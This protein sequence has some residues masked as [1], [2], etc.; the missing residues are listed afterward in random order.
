VSAPLVSV[1][2]PVYNGADC[3]GAAIDSILR[4]TFRDFE[5]I[6]INDGSTRDDTAGV[7]E[8]AAVAAGDARLRVVN[9]DRNR[10]LAGALN[11]GISLARGRY[12]ARQDQDDISL[13]ERLEAQVQYLE[14][15]PDCALLG[16]RAEVWVGKTPSGRHLDHPIDNASLQ[17]E[18][19]INSPFVHPSV[20]MRRSALDAVGPY[21]TAADRQPEDFELWSRIARRFSVANLP[22]R[23][24]IYREVPGSMSRIGVNPF[25]QGVIRIAT[26][27]LTHAGGGAF[28]M[29]VCRDAAALINGAYD[30]VSPHCDIGAI[31]DLVRAAARRIEADNPGAD[32]ACRRD[33]LIC[34][35]L[36]HDKARR[37]LG[38]LR[39]MLRR[40]PVVGPAAMRLARIVRDRSLSQKTREQG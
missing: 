36:E 15:H 7:L 30:G 1:I 21:A 19:L 27:N 39:N 29:T 24:V 10:G 33:R 38:R 26:E 12:I 20:V 25:Q 22:E 37:P 23:L 31:C 13:P 32:L 3:V 2:L 6:A 17:F 8:R 9:L 35:L 14:A 28:P 5:L 11:N 18:L 4:Q 34:N 16:T 40:T